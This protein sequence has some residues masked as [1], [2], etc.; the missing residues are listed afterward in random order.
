MVLV[1]HGATVDITLGPRDEPC[2]RPA[3]CGARRRADLRGRC[4]GDTPNHLAFAVTVRDGALAG[5][6]TQTR[7]GQVR[8]ARVA[9]TKQ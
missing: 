8:K 2:S 9:F 7:D 5:T 1:D 3:T 4:A 6:V